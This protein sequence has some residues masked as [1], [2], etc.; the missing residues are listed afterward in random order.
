MLRGIRGTV[1]LETPARSGTEVAPGVRATVAVVTP[2]F[3][4]CEF[5]A[6]PFSAVV[7]C[8]AEFVLTK[9]CSRGS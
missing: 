6:A 5:S 1:A 9:R 4:T 2:A 8:K 7:S 3:S